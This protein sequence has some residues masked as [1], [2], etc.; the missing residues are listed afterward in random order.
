MG[1]TCGIF[2]DMLLYKMFTVEINSTGWVGRVNMRCVDPVTE[3]ART[4][5]IIETGKRMIRN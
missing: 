4:L 3:D 1:R 2:G 5:L